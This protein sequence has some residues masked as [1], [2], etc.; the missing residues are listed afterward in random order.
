MQNPYN[1]VNEIL[2][3]IPNER[4]KEVLVRRFGLKDG[5]RQT[6]EAIGRDHKITRERV[7][8]IEE[9]GLAH[10]KQP[11]IKEKI[12]PIF[13]ALQEHLTEHGELKREDR[14]YDD[15]I[16]ICYPAKEIER[17][18]GAG[19]VSDLD[20]CRS[21]FY[22]ILTL[23][24]DFER[25]PEDDNFYSVWTVNGNSLK[26]AKKTI[27]SLVRHLDV[28]K[29]VLS[30]EQLLSAAK[31][32]FP[33][34]SAKA[35][36]S[37]VDASKQIEQNHLGHFGLVYWP[38]I[39]PRGVKD[40]A[41]I[42]LKNE[43]K[44]LHFSQVT[45]KINKI[46][47]SKRLAYVQTVHNELIKDKRFVLVGRGLYALSQW[48]YEP[49]TVSQTISQILKNDGPLTKEYI[50]NKVLQKRLVKENTVL[51]NLQ[52]RKLFERDEQGRY[53]VKV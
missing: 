28:Q 39:S 1:L 14:L 49:G 20:R 45:E 29:Q 44:P 11:K 21:A 4:T 25:L 52:N 7:R 35:I 53:A 40:K 27:D 22:L 37:Y 48:G 2:E 15:L 26:T 42:V 38:E 9:N 34:L 47:P 31:L 16:Y 46:L 50:I 10:L 36:H 18:K 17:L 13:Q 33:E 5:R 24:D 51:I 32:I 3:V 41:Y 19:N 23:G 8:Q 6:L 12:Q 30:P 43:G